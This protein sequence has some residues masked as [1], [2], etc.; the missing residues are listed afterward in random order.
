M[1]YGDIFEVQKGEGL[2]GEA[3]FSFKQYIGKGSFI[4]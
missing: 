2:I 3:S 1:C 4:G